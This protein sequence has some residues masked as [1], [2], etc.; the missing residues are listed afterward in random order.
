MSQR[1]MNRLTKGVVCWGVVCR[2]VL[3]GRVAS[4]KCGWSICTKQVWFLK[5]P[6]CRGSVTRK[7]LCVSGA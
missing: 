6:A 2:G 1:K 7:G 5:V 3:W 4:R